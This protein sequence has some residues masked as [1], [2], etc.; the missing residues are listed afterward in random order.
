MATDENFAPLRQFSEDSSL[1]GVRLRADIAAYEADTEAFARG[2]WV[3][4]RHSTF[5]HADQERLWENEALKELAA[6]NYPHKDVAFTIHDLKSR[7]HGAMQRT[8]DLTPMQTARGVAAH[9]SYPASPMTPPK[10]PL[11]ISSKIDTV[12][13]D[14]HGFRFVMPLHPDLFTMYI[15]L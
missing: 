15:S 1:W 14:L 2:R 8:V 12:S 13:C 5:S 9:A 4:G 11:T 7:L 6:G 3:Y 10:L